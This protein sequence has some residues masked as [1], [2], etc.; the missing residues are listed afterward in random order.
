LSTSRNEVRI[1]VENAV[2]NA[3]VRDLD[4]TGEAGLNRVQWDLRANPED[5]DDNQGPRVAPGTYRVVLIVDETEQS[6]L[7]NVLADDWMTH[8]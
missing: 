8:P 3:V 4:A 1:R 6:A 5:E 2:T 7:V